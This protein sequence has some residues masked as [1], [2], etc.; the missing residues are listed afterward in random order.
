MWSVFDPDEGKPRFES[1][2]GIGVFRPGWR[3]TIIL[4]NEAEAHFRSAFKPGVYE[5][6]EIANRALKHHFAFYADRLTRILPTIASRDYIE[7]VLHQYEQSVTVNQLDNDNRLTKQEASQWQKT[8]PKLRRALKYLAERT[9]LLWPPE[10][11]PVRADHT[12]MLQ[13]AEMALSCAEQLVDLY[14][15]SD[16]VFSLFPDETVLEVLPEGEVDIFRTRYPHDF[17]TDFLQRVHRDAAHRSEY[18]PL[19]DLHQIPKLQDP[20]LADAFRDAIGLSYNDTLAVLHVVIDQAL[21]RPTGF[22]TPFCLRTM[23]VDEVARCAGFPHDAVEKALAGFTVSRAGM[24]IEGREI[25]RPKQEYR[26][27][28]RGFFEMPHS[29]GSH[30]TWS[31]S[32]AQE[33]YVVLLKEIALKQV[34]LE[35]RTAQVDAAVSKLGCAVGKWFESLVAENLKKLGIMGL[36]SIKRMIGGGNASVRIPDEVGEI[37]FLGYSERDDAIIVAECK[38]VRGGTEPRFFRDEINVFTKGSGCHM[39]QL[40]RKAK[41]V[42]SEI[43]T[44]RIALAATIGLSGVTRTHRVISVLVSHYPS[45]A[46]YFWHDAPC[47]SLTELMLDYKERGHW[48]YSIG[49]YDNLP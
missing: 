42:V 40:A 27:Y 41:W 49:V 11:A 15:T 32:M 7:F 36:H 23:I 14:M 10:T 22:Q 33:S 1:F 35:W 39:M 13:Q 17:T 8:G 19:R 16:K 20:Y 31:K 44:L 9:V 46:S 5:G 3:A 2:G 47:V 12:Q 25:F 37:D 38:Y 6:G 43:Q 18:V 4:R 30:L 29:S 24:E 28:R 34:P 21:P 26:A 48:P 45:C